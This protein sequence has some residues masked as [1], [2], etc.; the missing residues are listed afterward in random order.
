[1]QELSSK[2][3]V[4]HSPSCAYQLINQRMIVVHPKE[5]TIHRLNEVA[6]SIWQFL[7]EERSLGEIADLLTQEYDVEYEI[8]LKDAIGFVE[9][10]LSKG[11]VQIKG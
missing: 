7:Q 11:L 8:A 3:R 9:K 4:I 5:R 6:T 1:M 2:T 10:L